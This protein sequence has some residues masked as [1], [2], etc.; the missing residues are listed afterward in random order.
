MQAAGDTR[1]AAER[2][3]E[4]KLADSSFFQPSSSA[5]TLDSSVPDLVAHWMEDFAS[6]GD[7]LVEAFAVILWPCRR[8]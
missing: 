5:L 6:D 7:C 1:K 2:A 3:L 4:A 8:R